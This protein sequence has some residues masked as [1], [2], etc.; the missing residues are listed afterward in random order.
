MAHFS[1]GSGWIRRFLSQNQT[2]QW[3]RHKSVYLPVSQ[4]FSFW[5]GARVDSPQPT[6]GRSIVW[7]RA[8]SAP[9]GGVLVTTLQ[10]GNAVKP[11]QRFVSARSRGAAGASGRAPTLERGSQCGCKMRIA[12]GVLPRMT[13]ARLRDM[14]ISSRTG[15]FRSAL[16]F[17][18]FPEAL[19]FSGEALQTPS[20]NLSL[21][22]A[23]ELG[24]QNLI[25]PVRLQRPQR[26]DTDGS[27]HQVGQ[28][29]TGRVGFLRRHDDVKG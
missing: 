9:G 25:G 21:W 4:Q 26:L 12:A 2:P 19:R 8:R 3:R 17:W 28:L 23:A 14:L 20:S 24:F 22:A 6:Q 10:R 18:G 13:T 7:T 29:H 1:D 16:G 15:N 5:L 27:G 11:L